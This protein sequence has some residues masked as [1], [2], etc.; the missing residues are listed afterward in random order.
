MGWLAAIGTRILAWISPYLL[1]LFQFLFLKWLE[2]A[3]DWYTKQAEKKAQEKADKANLENYRKA[4]EEKKTDEEIS[5]AA[6]DLLN[7]RRK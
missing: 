6:E 7:G 1:Q 5:T 2:Q 4:I 3:K